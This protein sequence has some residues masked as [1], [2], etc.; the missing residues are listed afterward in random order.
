MGCTTVPSSAQSYKRI[1]G[2]PVK[3]TVK[4]PE[5]WIGS[6]TS[7]SRGLH[8]N[9]NCTYSCGDTGGR[10]SPLRSHTPLPSFSCAESMQILFYKYWRCYFWVV[11]LI[12]WEKNSHEHLW[13]LPGTCFPS[14]LKQLHFLSK[15]QGHQCSFH[16]GGRKA[17]TSCVMLNGKELH[18]NTLKNLRHVSQVGGQVP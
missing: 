17:I 6:P 3:S 13:K 2:F 9:G 4:L 12:I 5:R 11:C 10:K 8:C 1:N 14:E 16:Q 7:I 18:Y 15:W